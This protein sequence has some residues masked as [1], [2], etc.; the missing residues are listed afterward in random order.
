MAS[1]TQTAKG[2]RAQL[3]VKGQRDSGTFPT[4]KDAQ[5]WAGKRE[6]ELRQAVAGGE[7]SVKT[8]AQA[9]ERYGEEVAEKH[10]GWRNELVR[11]DAFQRQPGFPARKRLAEVTPADLSAWR[12]A[13]LAVNARGSVLRDMTLLSSVFET[14]R[15]E[16]QWIAANPMKDVRRPAEPD[17]RERVISAREVLAMCHALGYH[18]GPVRSVGQ[19]V[20][21]C[22]LTAL[23][24][25]MRAG[26]LCG[27]EWGDVFPTHCR[28]HITKNGSA[29]DVPLS[30]R[31]RAHIEKMRGF[32]PALV[33]GLK[34]QSL[35]AM[36]RKYR[37]RAGLSG[38][39]FHDSRH[40]AA[41]MMARKIGALDLCKMFGWK[42]TKMALVYYNPSAADIAA[43][44]D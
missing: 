43:R 20:A 36:F 6:A 25:G 22:F 8:L 37:Q 31:A 7:G 30:R 3:Y 5:Q 42:N 44:L 32:D 15:R 14:A 26:E 10:R 38:F 23:R 19:A 11:L 12:D 40:T 21:V 17:H 2:W 18:G 24:T 13:R 28:L 41:T 9:L 27:L 39:T 35:D 33:F 16:W 1:F 29:R 4:K 34:S